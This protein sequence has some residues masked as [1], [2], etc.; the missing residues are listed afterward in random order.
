MTILSIVNATIAGLPDPS[1]QIRE[2]WGRWEKPAGDG[3]AHARIV[4]PIFDYNTAARSV[5]AAMKLNNPTLDWVVY[6][7]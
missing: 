5:N 7:G 1:W 2:L 4:T 6:H 3:G